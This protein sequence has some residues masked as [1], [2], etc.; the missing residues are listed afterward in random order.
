[1]AEDSAVANDKTTQALFDQR[2]STCHGKSPIK[3]NN[4]QSKDFARGFSE[5]G[6][7]KLSDIFTCILL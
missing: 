3:N 7:I 4:T 6:R 1:M 5:K 2:E